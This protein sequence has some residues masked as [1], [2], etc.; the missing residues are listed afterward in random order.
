MTPTLPL[1]AGSPPL[2]AVVSPCGL[3]RYTLTRAWAHRSWCWRRALWIGLNPSTA[4][5]EIDDP[6]IRRMVGFSR[7]WGFGSL[8]VVNL[9]AWRATD[10][11][12]LRSVPDPVG[13]DND[14]C[15]VEAAAR[16]SLIVACWGADPM[17]ARRSRAV[18]DLLAPANV[19]VVCLGRTRD[20]H[21][22]HPLYLSAATEQERFQ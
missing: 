4:D 18:L 22:R 20:G 3:Y 11:R 10:P 5:A 7:A 8:E 17:V 14:R 19:D 15:I 13:P 16:A 2:A 6:T 9:F 1:F 12:A 21:P